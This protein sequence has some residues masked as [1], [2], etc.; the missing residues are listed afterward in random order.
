MTD[1]KDQCKEKKKQSLNILRLP[2]SHRLDMFRKSKHDGTGFVLIFSIFSILHPSNLGLVTR[3]SLRRSSVFFFPPSSSS[4]PRSSPAAQKPHRGGHPYETGNVC[5]TIADVSQ[6]R[7]HLTDVENRTWHGMNEKPQIAQNILKSAS[8]DATSGRPETLPSIQLQPE[9]TDIGT[10]CVLNGAMVSY[11]SA[12]AAVMRFQTR[13][14]SANMQTDTLIAPISASLKHTHTHN[15]QLS[16]L[17][18]CKL[19][20]SIKTDQHKNLS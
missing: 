5:L 19:R 1:K 4:S 20:S 2:F 6:N 12:P 14:R 9:I 11:V 3:H 16:S 13:T 15:Y 7:R 8:I 18:P 17:L 10:S